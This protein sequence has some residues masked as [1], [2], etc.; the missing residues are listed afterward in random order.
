MYNYIID[1]GSQGNTITQDVVAELSLKTE[2]FGAQ[3]NAWGNVVDLSQS[4]VLTITVYD[5][6]NQSYRYKSRFL[7]SQNTAPAPFVLGLPFLV[8]ANP[9]HDYDTGRFL[10][11]KG[12]HSKAQRMFL[13]SEKKALKGVL[14]MSNLTITDNF[15][16]PADLVANMEEYAVK[17]NSLQYDKY[18]DVYNILPPEY[19]DFADIFQ[20]AEKQSLP[21]RGPHDHT[22]DLEPGQQPPFGKLYLMSPTE[23]DALRVYLDKAIEAGIIQ[24]SISPAASPVMFMPK[25][26][27]SL[28]LVI[29]YR[30][31]NDITIKNRYPLPLISDMLDRL[32]GAKMFT[33]LDCKDAY[34]R[35]RIKGGDKWKT[36]FC[37]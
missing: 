30:R 11:R 8:N 24:K 29:D 2:P 22:I 34:N 37:T 26:D 3:G 7:V 32:Q 17:M 18:N 35:V 9:N 25:A 36:A 5:S 31:L 28:R 23:L 10:W 12:K 16:G 4:V 19:H 27:G 20:A 6:N 13:A 1:N 15:I 14:H 33:K 21:E